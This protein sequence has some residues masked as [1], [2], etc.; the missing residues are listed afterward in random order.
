VN[1]P[2]RT[3]VD[4]PEL[5]ATL[6]PVGGISPHTADPLPRAQER[7][8]LLGLDDEPVGVVETIDVRIVRVADVDTAFVRDEGEGFE[9]VVEWR[10]A[11]ERFW[12]SN[13]MIDELTDD[14]LIVCERFRL[15]ERG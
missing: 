1:D 5:P 2:D 3:D 14:T 7:S 15:I 9:T 4:D 8:L 12:I 6:Q 10:A 11:H 13:G